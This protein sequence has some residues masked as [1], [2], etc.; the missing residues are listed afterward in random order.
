MVLEIRNIISLQVNNKDSIRKKEVANIPAVFLVFLF[1]LHGSYESWAA[2][3]DKRLG[4]TMHH[5]YGYE[6]TEI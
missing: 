4:S 6:N 5:E 3:D 1:P 2:S